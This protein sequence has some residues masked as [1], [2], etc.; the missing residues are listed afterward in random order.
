MK[1]LVAILFSII[2]LS[3]VSISSFAQTPS[4]ANHVVIN[5]V[6]TN[7]PGDDA[8]N[9]SEWVELY[10]PTSSTVDLS[11]WK[12]ASTTVLKK[13]LTIPSGT[14]I[15]PGKFKIFS[16]Q[17]SW[18]TDIYEV[19]ELIDKSGQ[20]IDKTPL[21][22]DV[23]NDFTSWQ[24]I[25][26]GYDTDDIADWKYVIATPGFTNGKI[27]SQ[28]ATDEVSITVN[29]NKE[30]Y[31]FGETVTLSG[32]V[33]KKV[34]I[35][36]PYFQ[37][38]KIILTITGPNYYNQFELYPD[39]NLKYKTSLNLHKVLGFNEGVYDV[40]VTYAGASDGAMFSLGNIAVQEKETTTTELSITT[41][42][43][44]YMPGEFVTISAKTTDMI[45]F[46]GLKFTVVNSNNVQ[47][48]DGS[49]FPNPSGEFTTK[50]FLSTVKPVYGEY[51]IIGEYFDQA[52]KTSFTVAKDVKEDALISL[53]TDKDVYGLGETV[54]ISGRLNSLWT[55]TFDLDIVQTTNK[56]LGVKGSSGGGFLF[57]IKDAVRLNGDGTFSYSFK[58]PSKQDRL[59][60]YQ[61]T[62]SK[63]IGTKSKS[64]VVVSN[65]ETYVASTDPLSL[66]TDKHVYDLGDKMK[67]SGAILNPKQ[68]STFQTPNVMISLLKGDGKPVTITGSSGGKLSDGIQIPYEL[69]AIPDKS[70][71]FS[72]T[73]DVKPGIFSEGK[74]TIVARYLD[75]K[76]STNVD[77]VKPLITDGNM[78]ITLDKEVYGLGNVVKLSG[79]VPPTA[80]QG[81]SI[82]LF[83]P[84]GSRRDSGASINNQQFSW[85]WNTPIAATTSSV[86][87]TE[88]RSLSKSNLGIYKVTVSTKSLN[89]SVFFKVSEDPANDTLV[90]P[91]L[92]VTTEK[93]IYKPGEKLK[94]TGEVTVRTQGT[95]GLVV[96]ER[97]SIQ[98]LSGKFPHPVIHEASVYPKQGGTFSS[99]FEL[100]ATIF[101]TGEYIVKAN[102]IKKQA[103]TR[104]S[105]ANDFIFGI[106]EPIALITSTDKDQ[107]YPGDTVIVTGK[108]NKLIYL[109]AYEISVIKKSEIEITCGTFYCGK[110]TSTPTQIRPS[111]SGAFSYVY[112]IPNK[113]SSIGLYE[114]IVD[115]DFDTKSLKFN[116]VEKPTVVEPEP[117]RKLIEKENRIS[118]NE[119]FVSTQTKM[120]D[121]LSWGPRVLLGSMLT[122]DRDN[123]SIVNLQVT[124][125][126]GICVI[127]QAE[128]CLVKDSTRK[129][130]AIYE[131]VEVDGQKFNVRY[132]GSDVR[133]EK[134]SIL[135]ESDSDFLPDTVWD[136]QV[137]KDNQVSRLYY[138]INYSLIE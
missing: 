64:I 110:H 60:E 1:R 22:T 125:E 23:K 133:L 4:I 77:I 65:P 51:T 37:P 127:G 116:V 67:I 89:K 124:S 135:P 2:L 28:S 63:D 136:I 3:S 102:Y 46:E 27:S 35:E 56:A 120:T 119:I 122:P 25:Y 36:K 18:F 97:V 84:D 34:T 47:I 131:V 88:D 94:V 54:K 57:K 7:P 86:K 39:L 31:I 87:S 45:P 66:T 99:L 76:T 43:T 59:G 83:K 98:V 30:S 38:A 42:K 8:V 123:T 58:I 53:W 91:P 74:Y 70:G 126:S 33:S 15:E 10:N 13:T 81:V 16:N 9:I 121:D 20:V 14:I 109:K 5:E 114:I 103:E 101:P 6:D 79:I 26:D 40:S 75:L 49:L 129:P 11:G 128:E 95:E 62:V 107:Y 21:I 132:S 32:S 113:P 71:F 29:S 24:R 73:A 44:D 12:I 112:S 111:P 55:P 50:F 115:I 105:V 90:I 80:E 104:F 118:D 78:I 96:P 61:I 17:Q 19:V 72:T 108:P 134:F 138:K 68:S 93:S 117:L 85:E 137:I 41:D 52:A 69:T 130:G 100:P 106:D 82:T 92:S 48:F